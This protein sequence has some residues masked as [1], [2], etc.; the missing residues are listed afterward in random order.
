MNLSGVLQ[1][2][3]ELVEDVDGDL[4]TVGHRHFLERGPE[5]SRQLS[6]LRQA[7]LIPGRRIVIID[8]N[9]KEAFVGRIDKS[10]MSLHLFD[11]Q[12]V[13]VSEL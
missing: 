1:M 9:S 13:Q 11:M 2:S 10:S 7:N 8:S 6:A 12:F 3:D 4:R 5:L